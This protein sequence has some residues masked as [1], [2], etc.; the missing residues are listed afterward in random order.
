MSEKTEP[1]L[2]TIQPPS[3]ISP[4]RNWR[5]WFIGRPLSSADAADEAVGKLVGLAIFASDALS[6]TAYATQEI[7]VVLAAAGTLAFGYAFPIAVAI[8]LLIAIV[9][10][11]YEQ[12]IHAYPSGG[13][14]YIV[15][16]ENLG[17]IPAQ[18]AGA[19]LLTGYILTVAV[20]I[21]A[22]VAQVVS[23]LPALFDYRVQIALAL[24]V[25]ITI[26]NLRGVRESGIAFALPA[27]LFLASL[28]LTIG[29]G[30]FRA[31]TGS[32]GTVASPPEMVEPAAVL[33]FVTPFLLLRAFSSGTSA[34]TGI[35][36][37]ANGVT[38][39]KEPSSRNARIVLMW[40]GAILA[41]LF[42]GITFLARAVGAVPSEEETVVSQIARTV[43]GGEGLLYLA[44]VTM[45]SI[46]LILAANTA[47]AGFPRL[48]AILARDGYL[49]RQLAYRGSRLVYSKGIVA[50]GFLAGLLIFLFNAS[51]SRLI[52]LYAVG[53]FL[54]FT[55]SQLGMA[56]RWWQAGHLRKDEEIITKHSSVLAYEPNYAVKMA[57]NAAGAFCT[58]VVT[59]VF[60]ITNFLSGA[61]I[62]L[63][64][65]P[66]QVFIFS[67]IHDHYQSLANQLT[68]EKYHS[69][70]KLTRYRV[71]L[72]IGG[73]HQGTLRAL[74]FA[75]SLTN[76]VTAVYI[77]MDEEESERIKAKWRM[78]GEGVRLVV[79]DSPFRL[80]L[81]P[82][83]EYIEAIYK[84]RQHNEVIMVV[85]PQFVSY[86]WWTGPLHNQTAF[87]LRHA[88]LLRPGIVIIEVP[89]QVR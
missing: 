19:A 85:V 22:G 54:S 62:V 34:L 77:S 4:A 33:P 13:G 73:V 41:A 38:A 82:L 64:L 59:L 23:A 58:G 67:A 47:F 68:L 74:H 70:P 84:A 43:A 14:A 55:L 30:L 37:I 5:S 28:L 57:V 18:I 42:L 8:V 78:Y 25:F 6:S 79:L 21:S 61:W 71:I 45:T 11:S 63:S 24:V 15:A 10:I 26:I 81:E 69:P 1:Q 56:R 12:T 35:E 60:G 20:S 40:M 83:L 53:V 31:I 72:P 39:F 17:P 48:A 87:M 80:L 29:I 36:A 44:V 49:P 86:R 66:V 7:L 88:L 89:Y 2:T 50:L 76:D 9:V 75:H 3:T 32:L 52:P 27:Y 46:I 16:L 51:V 65:I